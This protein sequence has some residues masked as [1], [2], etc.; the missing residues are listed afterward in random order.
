MLRSSHSFPSAEAEAGAKGGAEEEVAGL[1]Q[2]QGKA[3]GAAGLVG[4]EAAAEAGAVGV[5][6]EVE[7][8]APE[9]GADLIGF[10]TVS[11]YPE[12]WHIKQ[13]LPWRSRHC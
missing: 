3:G 4:A 8:G 1:G 6:P 11:A 2:A 13:V 5:S 10:H 7:A 12:Q 9:D